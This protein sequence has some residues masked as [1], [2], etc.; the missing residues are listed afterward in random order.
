MSKA[1]L[2]IP[3]KEESVPQEACGVTAIISK[4]DETVTHLLPQMNRMLINRGRD[5]AGEAVLD[6]STGQIVVYKG[7]GKVKEVFPI[8]FDFSAHNLLSDR[9]IGHNRYG[10]DDTYDKDS[11]SCAQPM[12]SEYKGRKI[13]IAYNGNL[14]ESERLKLKQR[15]PADVPEGASVDTSDILNAI[16]TARGESWEERIENGLKGVHLAYSLTILTD[17]GEVIGVRGPSGHWP[18]WVGEDDKKIILSSETRVDEIQGFNN[19]VWNEVKP[20]ELVNITPEGIKRKQVFPSATFSPCALHDMYGARRNSRM[21]EDLRYKDFREEAGRMLAREHPI[22]ADL[23][24]GIPETGLD[25]AK[26]YAEGLGRTSTEIITKRED[27]D[28]DEQ[29]GFIGKNSDEIHEVIRS[30]YVILEREK[31][32]SKKVV[33]VDDS[34]IRGTTAGGDP[35]NN[36]S[37]SPIKNT[38]GYVALLREAGAAE[39]HTLFALPKF[40]NGCDMGY[41]IRKDQLVAV[42]KGE[43]GG[44]EI[45]D[46]QQVAKRIG[47]DSVYYMSVKGIESLYEWA[48]GEKGIGCMACMGQ[49]H[50]LDV[51][52]YRV[53]A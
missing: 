10:T 9:G 17:Q 25:I 1:E 43:D 29:R 21:K 49:S 4:N 51:I 32:K 7:I 33:T 37:E 44:Y 14:P 50:P 2:F 40:V 22:D 45:L 38:K 16:I 48:Y 42:V 53:V 35:L 23:Y 5:A 15:I 11:P 27:I 19:I 20:G 31:V 8:N 41:Y 47:A 3:H 52:K 12:V 24:I 34:N 30:K 18:L 36:G 13:A 28:G 39:V 46:E 6:W 26:G